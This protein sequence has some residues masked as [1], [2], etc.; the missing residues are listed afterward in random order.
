M[1]F[2]FRFERSMRQKKVRSMGF[3]SPVSSGSR[4]YPSRGST[5]STRRPSAARSRKVG[6]RSTSDTCA[7]TRSGSKRRGIDT[8][9]G[10]RADHSKKHCLNHMPRSPSISP[11]SPA[12]TTTVSSA[13]PVSCS[14]RRTLP[15]FSST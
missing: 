2:C 8:I 14:V 1:A 5:G 13:R 10:T 11:W 3:E 6:S 12:N 9:S 4:L 7:A 15:I